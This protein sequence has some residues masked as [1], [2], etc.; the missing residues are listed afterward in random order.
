[1]DHF[2]ILPK[3]PLAPVFS[4]FP[5]RDTMVLFPNTKTSYIYIRFLASLPCPSP[6]PS[7]PMNCPP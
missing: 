2:P 7:P 6:N 4:S 3:P 1:M 5:D